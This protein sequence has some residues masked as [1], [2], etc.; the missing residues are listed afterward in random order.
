MLLI[1][2]PGAPTGDMYAPGSTNTACLCYCTRYVPHAREH[3]QP[4]FMLTGAQTSD[5]CAPDR[6]IKRL[7]QNG[8]IY[9]YVYICI[10]IY[11]YAYVCVCVRVCV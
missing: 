5:M 3:K 2:S 4:I 6:E 8:D 9:V 7:L 1:C 10:F 11:V